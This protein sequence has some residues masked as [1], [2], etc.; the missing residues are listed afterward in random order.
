M[1]EL[2][3]SLPSRL[4]FP[5]LVVSIVGAVFAVDVQAASVAASMHSQSWLDILGP[6]I[7]GA[8]LATGNVV[9]RLPQVI[10]KTGLCRSSI[11]TRIAAGEFPAGF[12]LGGRARGWLEAEIEQWIT[13]RAESRS[14]DA[15]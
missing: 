13:E 7:F 4:R 3:K 15:A 2:L 14:A 1:A 10:Q 11:Y 9:L 8:T 12:S 5:I 6:M